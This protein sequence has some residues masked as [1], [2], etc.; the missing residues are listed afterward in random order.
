MV[1][2]WRELR[3]ARRKGRRDGRA[4]VPAPEDEA[5]PFDLRE[6][7]ARSEERAHQLV[8]RWRRDDAALEVELAELQQRTADAA[9][10]LAGA[11]A[12]RDVAREDHERRRVDEDARL[13]RLQAQLEELPSA[14][15]PD[16]RFEEPEVGAPALV[17]IGGGSP[18]PPAPPRLAVAHEPD[19]SGEDALPLAD[20]WAAAAPAVEDAS[21]H[22]IGRFVYWA[23]IALIIAG[24]L[25]LNALAFRLFGESD[26]FTYI[27]TASLAVALIAI[28]HFLGSLVSRETHTTVERTLIGVFTLVPI[29]GIAVV[30]LIRYDYLTRAG[31]DAIGPVLGTLAFAL[32]NLLVFV[33]AAGWSYLRHD[34]RTLVNRRAAVREA[35]RERDRA[36]RRLAERERTRR[37]REHEE[38]DD[39]RRREEELHRQA[40]EAERE[41]RRRDLELEADRHR[42]ELEAR[43]QEALLKREQLLEAMRPIRDAAA[44]RA[45]GLVELDRAVEDARTALAELQQRVRGIDL[46]RR[47]LREATEARLR[48]IRAHR[49]RLVSAYCSANVRARKDHATPRCFERVPALVWPAGFEGSATEVA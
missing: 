14:D 4:G 28:A 6:M 16:V 42:A 34:P 5:I 46:E 3:D 20:A 13:A 23:V 45:R 44:E 24:E 30:S 25:P 49:D 10:R 35:E 19:G 7:L 36:E 41:R 15:A 18:A 39:A 12:R 40:A 29:A 22:G 27:M 37:A 17:P 47:A 26:L 48:E 38:Q 9:E 1:G 8:Q 32:I 21:W 43:K 11:E 2:S 31:D 33:A